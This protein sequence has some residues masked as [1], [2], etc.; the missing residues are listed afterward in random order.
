VRILLADDNRLFLEG[1]T[2]LLIAHGHEVVATATNGLEAIDR[3][4]IHRP[5]IVLMDVRM[6]RCDGMEAAR[7]IARAHPDVRIVMLT[8]SDEEEHLFEAIA[9]GAFGYLVKSMRGDELIDALAQVTD[10]VPP[11]SPGLAASLLAEFARRSGARARATTAETGDAADASGA[12]AAAG[13]HAAD[14]LTPRELDVLRAVAAGHTYAETATLLGVSERTVR[15]HMSEL[16]T[17]LHLAHR[18]QA[19]AY[20]AEAGLLEPQS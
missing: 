15:F 17:R 14:Q 1:L 12:G 5:D 18:S 20:A 16:L 13:D 4:R 9:A 19:I 10:G 3:T 8:T 2:D 7:A 11:F 6:P